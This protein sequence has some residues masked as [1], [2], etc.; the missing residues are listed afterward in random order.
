MINNVPGLIIASKICLFA[1]GLF[2]FSYLSLECFFRKWIR[3]QVQS[4]R[5]CVL[6][7]K[8]LLV[9]PVSDTSSAYISHRHLLSDCR[10]ASLNSSLVPASCALK[11]YR[12]V[13]DDNDEVLGPQVNI[14]VSAG[15]RLLVFLLAVLTGSY[16][17]CVRSSQHVHARTEGGCLRLLVSVYFCTVMRPNI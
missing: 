10:S 13:D 11:E 5:C 15:M 1:K 2:H 6:S 17:E 3:N 16:V 7:S 4:T 9:C 8:F 14:K 12:V